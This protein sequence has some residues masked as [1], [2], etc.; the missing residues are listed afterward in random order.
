MSDLPKPMFSYIGRLY[1]AILSQDF[2][3]SNVNM[4]NVEGV[5]KKLSR[6][7]WLNDNQDVYKIWV[8]GGDGFSDAVKAVRSY[9]AVVNKHTR[10]Q[11][12]KSKVKETK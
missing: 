3:P 2:N 1:D 11:K 12:S 8:L 9:S 5:I 6:T 4:E 10:Q 7:A